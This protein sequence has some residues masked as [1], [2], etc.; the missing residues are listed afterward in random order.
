MVFVY[1]ESEYIS[2]ENVKYLKVH[3]FLKNFKWLGYHNED[4]G[5]DTP[6]TVTSCDRLG[7]LVVAFGSLCTW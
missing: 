7:I 1:P 5:K 4:C 2:F 6:F 3:I